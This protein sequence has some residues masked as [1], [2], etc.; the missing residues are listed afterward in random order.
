MN[1]NKNFLTAKEVA[2]YLNMPLRTV[3]HL[4]KQ[5]RIK[6]IKIGGMWRYFKCDIEQ[7]RSFG[8]DFSKEPVRL[9]HYSKEPKQ[10]DSRVYP[11]INCSF[12]CQYLINLPPF[13]NIS[14]LGIIKNISAGGIL[15]I[16]NS[17]YFDKI[18]IDDPIDLKF[19]LKDHGN[20]NLRGRIIRINNNSLGIKFR[21]ISSEDKNLI[22]GYVG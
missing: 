20:M 14:N 12:Q 15:L 18:N 3:H 13:K 22:A 17:D 1:N 21:N 6:S 16:D 7:Y 10:K 4:S 8:T 5:G 19:V 2:S 9:T 11:R